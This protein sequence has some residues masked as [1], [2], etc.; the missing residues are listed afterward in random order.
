MSQVLIIFHTVLSL[1]FGAYL[2]QV[3]SI[4][5]GEVQN[6][7]QRNFSYTFFTII[8][9]SLVSVIGI[10]ATAVVIGLDDLL[11]TA[12]G[13]GEF[14][15]GGC[16]LTLLFYFNDTIITIKTFQQN[17]WIARRLLIAVI[18][19]VIN[20][21]VNSI[22]VILIGIRSELNPYFII[23]AYLSLSG[24]VSVGSITISIWFRIHNQSQSAEVKKSSEN[25]QI[26]LGIMKDE[27]L[28]AL[29][30][31]VV[32]LYFSS[33]NEQF[34]HEV[35]F[36]NL[37]PSILYAL[38]IINRSKKSYQPITVPKLKHH[39]LCIKGPK[40]TSFGLNNN[41]S[42]I[43][44]S[45]TSPTQTLLIHM[46]SD[47]GANEMQVIPIPPSED[48]LEGLKDP[49]NRSSHLAHHPQNR[50]STE[51]KHKNRMSDLDSMF[52]NHSFYSLR[53]NRN[54][55]EASFN[56][57]PKHLEEGRLEG[58]LAVIKT[59]KSIVQEN[60]RGY[61]REEWPEIHVVKK[62]KLEPR[63]S[64][65]PSQRPRKLTELEND[66]L[67]DILGN[68]KLV[69]TSTPVLMELS[70]LRKNLVV[71]PPPIP[72]SSSRF[73]FSSPEF[74]ND[75]QGSRRPSSPSFLAQTA[76]EEIRKLFPPKLN[77]GSVSP[78]KELSIE[79]GLI[80]ENDNEETVF[81]GRHKRA[82]KKSYLSSHFIHQPI[83]KGFGHH[84]ELKSRWKFNE[85]QLPK[86]Q[87]TIENQIHQNDVYQALD[88]YRFGKPFE[89]PSK[90]KTSKAEGPKCTKI[91]HEISTMIS[92][93]KDRN[94]NPEGLKRRRLTP[95]SEKNQLVHH[96]ATK[97]VDN[98]LL[99]C[100]VGRSREFNETGIQ[101]KDWFKRRPSTK[102]C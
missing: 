100:G 69:K 19:L 58:N 34:H 23:L 66:S 53:S 77:L 87:Q 15:K 52:D 95:V 37:L 61:M 71:P 8:I 31:L 21:A 76:L 11:M 9:S 72:S 63:I 67:E 93:K 83:K 40:L 25:L 68:P 49:S 55:S 38:A 73:K 80:G 18:S 41:S 2:S 39:N 98:L 26:S 54:G 59:N 10:L 78:R 62:I 64:L 56:Q 48:D 3:I 91:D 33:T 32:L 74:R 82:A 89:S 92:P 81:W 102:V 4:I 35:I 88:S 20:V 85:N 24:V 22:L 17:P 79:S 28:P 7:S 51:S 1:A 16:Q 57:I 30:Q 27:G 99:G 86:I 94:G 43:D 96:F 29:A 42:K 90:V 84:F 60:G 6:K 101:I 12:V 5:F 70:D 47:T 13:L 36:L 44:V 97:S 14:L 46:T 45:V 50:Y 75:L 65:L